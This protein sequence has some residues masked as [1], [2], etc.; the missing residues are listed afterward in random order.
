VLRLWVLFYDVSSAAES[1]SSFYDVSAP[2]E[3]LPFHEMPSAPE[4]PFFDRQRGDAPPLSSCRGG[5]GPG[6]AGTRIWPE[7]L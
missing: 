6:P 3:S 1:P 5:S 2:E 4:S 7:R